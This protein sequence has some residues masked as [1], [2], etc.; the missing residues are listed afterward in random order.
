MN[1][2]SKSHISPLDRTRYHCRPELLRSSCDHAKHSVTVDKYV[3][4]WINGRVGPV[5]Q[6]DLLGAE[7]Q[8]PLEGVSEAGSAGSRGM[9]YAGEGSPT[10]WPAISSGLHCFSSALALLRCAVGGCHWLT[11]CGCGL[12]AWC[13]QLSAAEAGRRSVGYEQSLYMGSAVSACDGRAGLGCAN[14]WSR[15]VDVSLHLQLWRFLLHCY[16]LLS[17]FHCLM[18]LRSA[19]NG[20]AGWTM[21]LWSLVS[22]RHPVLHRTVTLLAPTHPT[23][24][25]SSTAVTRPCECLSLVLQ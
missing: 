17:S 22:M 3:Q 21:I 10:S 16:H 5:R 13:M 19:G 12:R 25:T 4:H 11:L 1:A 15:R 7:I 23:E 6:C 20:S 18:L 24:V 9:H 14:E 8:L 2:E